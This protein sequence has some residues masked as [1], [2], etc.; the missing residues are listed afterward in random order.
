[1]STSAKRI[2]AAKLG[3]LL[4]FTYMVSYI[5]RINY[6]AVIVE[7]VSA[8]GYSKSE[9][10]LALTGSFF[11]YG[12]GQVVSGWLGDR[13]QPRTMVFLGLVIS[14]SMNIL[15]LF[16]TN[17]WI[18]A[19]IWCVNG[20][21]QA[22]MWPPIVRLMASLLTTEEFNRATLIVSWGSSF[23]T[24]FV[25]LIA[26]VMIMI[27]GYRA[28]F[29]FSATC[30]IIM[31]PIWLKL[32]PQIEA[33]PKVEKK[34]ARQ[35]G[36]MNAIFNPMMFAIMFAIVIQGSLR[37]GIATW[38]PSYI[39][40][41][42]DLGNRISI[43]TGVILPIFALV[44][45]NIVEP[46]HERWIKNPLF[47]AGIIFGVGAASAGLLLMVT[48]KYTILSIVSMALLSG[49]MHGVNLMLIC[50]LPGYFIKSGCVSLVSGILNACTYIGSAISTYGIAV[51]TEN[52]GWKV[53]IGVWLGISALG[54]ALCLICTPSWRRRF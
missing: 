33:Q 22:F 51:L 15:I 45:L 48:G 21:A 14:S 6:S 52:T 2:T 7:M 40:E 3:F 31:M 18:M 50:I 11:T 1:M 38:M 42:Y 10:S 26:P 30:G 23:G 46:I 17:P 34:E 12:F 54:A 13:I 9:L 8:T 39:S 44:C 35:G 41:T 47:F 5:T 19:A 27:S 36:L 37:D 24:I 43:L 29:A 20:F 32:C 25:Y 16:F 49:C 53:T 28:M 4:M